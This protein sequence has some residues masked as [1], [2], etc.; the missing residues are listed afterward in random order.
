MSAWQ[1]A[2]AKEQV[3]LRTPCELNWRHNCSSLA[4][5]MSDER[6]PLLQ[7]PGQTP[8]ISSDT[9]L[10]DHHGQ[11]CHLVGVR[12]LNLPPDAKHE[13]HPEALYVRA[14]RRRRNQ[15]RTYACTAALTNTLLLTQVVLGAALTGLGAS[16]SPGILIA[17]FGAV[18]TVIAG[19]IA[20]LKSRGQP[21][22]ARMF[23][24]DLERVVDEI[25]NSATMWFGISRNAHGYDAIDTDDQVTVRSEVARLTRLYDKAVKTNT[26]ND[27]DMYAA[28]LPGDPANAGLRTKPGQPPLPAAP[29]TTAPVSVAPAVPLPAASAPIVADP[30]DSPATKVPEP[31]KAADAAKPAEPPTE[32]SKSVEDSRDAAKVAAAVDVPKLDAAAGAE[33]PPADPDESPATAVHPRP[34]EDPRSTEQDNDAAGT[35]NPDQASSKDSLEESSKKHSPDDGAGS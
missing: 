22:R 23:R 12:P 18:N 14:I 10:G 29:A 20:F 34:H 32:A 16:N 5:K 6:T 9:H 35:N 8:A 21:M 17:I 7:F 4:T 31:A 3:V 11:F 19:V 24:D 2:S 1:Q 28:G 15:S 26:I 25:E 33:A 27:P 30:D 13:P